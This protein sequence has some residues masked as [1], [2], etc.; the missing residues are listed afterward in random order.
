MLGDFYP[1]FPPG[2]ED[3]W[4]GY[5]FHRPDLDAGM[6]V[7]FRREKATDSGREIGPHAL[8][9]HATY[10]LTDEDTRQT[11]QLSG[12]DLAH[13]HATIPTAPGAAILFY[14]RVPS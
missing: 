2:A 5:Q 7:V 9:P 8:N 4:Y 3:T 6:V 14:R 12:S 13:F 11:R 10:E 1:L